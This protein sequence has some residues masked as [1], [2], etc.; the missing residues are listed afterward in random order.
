MNH[1]LHS[2][3]LGDILYSLPTVKALGGGS[4]W[5]L[6][7]PGLGTRFPMTFER[8]QAVAPLLKAQPYIK[9]VY[10]CHDTVPLDDRD[11]VVDLNRFRTL[12]YDVVN[13]PLAKMYADAEGIRVNLK[14]PWLTTPNMS[15]LRSVVIARSAR[16]PNKDFPWGKVLERWGS[17]ATF[18]GTPAEYSAFVQEFGGAHGLMYFHTLDL[19][20]AAQVIKAAMLFIGNQSAPLAIAHGL[21]KP[22]LIEKF[23]NNCVYGRDNEYFKLEDVPHALCQ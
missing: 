9:E 6:D 1:F 20:D 8:I 15:Y 19:L 22:V 4:L 16:S 12:G 23:C 13:T 2:G 3:D 7:K 17:S 21:G 5:L 14:L 10:G 18:V 11:R